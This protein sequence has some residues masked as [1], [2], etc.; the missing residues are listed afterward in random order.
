MWS[1]YIYSSEVYKGKTQYVPEL[2]IYGSD[3]LF[4]NM[5]FADAFAYHL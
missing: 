3:T 2:A 5:Y 1:P 4:K